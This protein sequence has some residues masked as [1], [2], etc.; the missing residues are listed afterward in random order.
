MGTVFLIAAAPP[1][2]VGGGGHSAAASKPDAY[3]RTAAAPRM[4]GA[5]DDSQ[6][7]AWLGEEDGQV[8]AGHEAGEAVEPELCDVGG[9]PPQPP[10][11]VAP[12]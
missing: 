4:L 6:E 11:P 3:R 12:V 10:S 2:G 8:P 9:A 1:G 5:C 7:R